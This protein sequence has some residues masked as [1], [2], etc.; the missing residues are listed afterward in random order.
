MALV[1]HIAFARNVGD[2]MVA[3]TDVLAVVPAVYRCA[4]CDREIILR[5]GTRGQPYFIHADRQECLL[6]A[7]RALRAAALQV[8]QESRFVNAPPLPGASA[9][10][11]VRNPA[12]PLLEE[13]AVATADWQV[14]GLPV[15]LFAQAMSGDLV[16]SLAIPGLFDAKYRERVAN[17]GLAALEIALPKP[18]TL[19]TFAQLQEL[20]LRSTTNK[21]WLCHPAVTV[22]AALTPM[23]KKLHWDE[24]PAMLS[25]GHRPPSRSSVR[26]PEAQAQH[27]GAL[28]ESFIYKQQTLGH[29][30]EILEA[31]LGRKCDAWPAELD[32]EVKGEKAF[33]CDRRV[34]QADTFS[35]FVLAAGERQ[36]Q[37]WFSS[38]MVV[39]WLT[40]RYA[41]TNIFTNAE[42]V[43]VY[44]YL[45]ELSSRGFLAE[46]SGQRY[47]PLQRAL[48]GELVTLHWNSHPT[49]SASQLRNIS[50]D[51]HLPIPIDIVQWLLDVFDEG[52]PAV[53]VDRFA[54]DLATRLRAPTRT[55]VAFLLEAGLA[56]D[57]APR[58]TARQSSLF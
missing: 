17:L 28:T 14:D 23:E 30:I 29:K 11:K 24:A 21:H 46:H 34:W 41:L 44:Y 1:P 40:E 8:L 42:K 13:W 49:L 18:S 31:R 38:E 51:A 5:S 27:A 39:R 55:V 20:V 22:E 26:V 36:Q 37:R 47:T 54:V 12:K 19:H 35:K 6:G 25:G 56:Y 9:S 43:A 2:Y 3:A 10:R 32:I 48:A 33:G 7:Q 57:P 50:T 52:H 16:V 58:P 15:D 53:P 45:H 4:A